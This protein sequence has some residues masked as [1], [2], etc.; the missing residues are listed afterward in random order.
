MGYGKAYGHTVDGTEH[1]RLQSTSL[2]ATARYS[3]LTMS[4]FLGIIDCLLPFVRVDKKLDPLAVSSSISHSKVPSTL[5]ESFRCSGLLH[6][7]DSS[8]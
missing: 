8:R 1:Q 7:L 6:I 2:H 3:E 4:G 5:L